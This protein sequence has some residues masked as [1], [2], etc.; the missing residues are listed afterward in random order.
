[1]GKAKST[2]IFLTAIGC[3]AATPASSCAILMG[4]ERALIVVPSHSLPERGIMSH[5]L[6]ASTMWV[7]TMEKFHYFSMT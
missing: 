1:V 2:P 3:V 4:S 7:P 5:S 6:F